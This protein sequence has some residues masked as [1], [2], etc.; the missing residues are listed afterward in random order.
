MKRSLKD[1]ISLE[2]L[3]HLTY[4]PPIVLKIKNWFPFLLN[5]AGFRNL[6]C[7]F[8]FRNGIKIKTKEG[9]DSATLAVIF[10]KKEY[11]NVKDN[12]V[13]IDIGA[14]IGV[15][16]IFAASTSKNTVVYAYEPV[17]KTFD[18]LLE[19]IKLNKFEKKVL[20]FNLGVF[21]RKG[22]RKLYFGD[23]SPFNSLYPKKKKE[24][25]E[26][27][28]ISLKDVFDYN[29][30]E[31]CDILKVDCEGAEYE[32]LYNTPNQYLKKIKEIRLEYHNL[33]KTYNI[34]K[35]IQFLRGQGFRVIKMKK[36]FDYSGIVWL[37]RIG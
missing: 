17:P 25:L 26:I 20:P 27:N 29:K 11:G 3:K 24:Y 4:I 35:L 30:I 9:I 7:L 31:R 36:D 13:V 28:C 19:N 1:F 16:S 15:Y 8:A 22:K 2:A 34:K 18:S 12:S 23:S 6:P 14:N 33:N 10:I 32:I 5:Y 21:S 37:R